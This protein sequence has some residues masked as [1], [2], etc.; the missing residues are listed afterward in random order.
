MSKIKTLYSTETHFE[1]H[2]FLFCL[3]VFLFVNCLSSSI[4][5]LLA[6]NTTVLQLVSPT[7]R[8]HCMRTQYTTY[9]V[10]QLGEEQCTVLF[11]D[12]V[13]TLY[14]LHFSI[15]MIICGQ[16]ISFCCQ[17]CEPG[18]S[19][20]QSKGSFPK[21]FGHC[22]GSRAAY[23]HTIMLQV[24]QIN[25]FCFRYWLSPLSCCLSLRMISLPLFATRTGTMWY[26]LWHE[27]PFFTGLYY[28]MQATM[29]IGFGFPTEVSEGKK[30][31]ENE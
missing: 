7:Y 19:C 18:H 14:Y 5:C 26:C 25:S 16:C 6:P 9:V 3:S 31:G 8:P 1:I 30:I 11:A 24:M 15:V 17:I 20:Y 10:G 27:W 12:V 13:Y 28:L 22:G 2:L 29:S 21:I 23:F 4:H